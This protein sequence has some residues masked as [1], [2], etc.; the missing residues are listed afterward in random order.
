MQFI[1]ELRV[2]PAVSLVGIENARP[3]GRVIVDDSCTGDVGRRQELEEI[4][5][6]RREPGRGND[7]AGKGRAAGEC[8]LV[9]CR[10]ENLALAALEILAQVAVSP[11]GAAG[12]GESCWDRGQSGGPGLFPEALVIAEEEQFVFADGSAD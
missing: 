2:D 8:R 6:R 4:H 7:V 12:P 5:R 11:G 10:V 3:G 1:G 9:G